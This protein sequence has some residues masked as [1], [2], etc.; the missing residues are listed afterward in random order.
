MDSLFPFLQ[1]LTPLQHVG[2][3]RRTV[4]Y[5]QPGHSPFG[6]I[7]RLNLVQRVIPKPVLTSVHFSTTCSI[8]LKPS[9]IRRGIKVKPQQPCMG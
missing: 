6:N 1:G 7:P 9:I 5:R 8:T 4:N 3:S 2:L